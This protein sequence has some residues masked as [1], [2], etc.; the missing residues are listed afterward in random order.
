LVPSPHESR[1][2]FRFQHLLSPLPIHC[3]RR[4]RPATSLLVRPVLVDTVQVRRD[5]AGQARPYLLSPIWPVH[6]T[7]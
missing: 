1:A 5:R 7:G 4:A 3:R 6:R 2:P